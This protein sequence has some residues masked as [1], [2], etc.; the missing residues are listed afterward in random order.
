MA[1]EAGADKAGL[2]LDHCGLGVPEVQACVGGDAREERR[3]EVQIAGLA[4]G[5][6]VVEQGEDV[7]P[8]LEGLGEE[9]RWRAREISGGQPIGFVVRLAGQEGLIVFGS[10]RLAEKG[11]RLG[12]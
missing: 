9:R 11:R 12:G 7:A 6:V 1:G 4:Q 10:C 5:D 2:G 8:A 3:D